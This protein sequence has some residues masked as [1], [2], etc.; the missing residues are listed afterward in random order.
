MAGVHDDSPD[1]H[2]CK[3]IDP[4]SEAIIGQGPHWGGGGASEAIIGQGPHWGLFFL[5]VLNQG[6]ITFKHH[7]TQIC[8]LTFTKH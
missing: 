6:S 4:S 1:C 3:A 7:C 8:R 5:Q 2:E